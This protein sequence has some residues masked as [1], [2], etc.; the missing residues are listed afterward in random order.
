MDS[1]G[2]GK[3]NVESVWYITPAYKG[4]KRHSCL[5]CSKYCHFLPCVIGADEC[6]QMASWPFFAAGRL[7][8]RRRGSVFFVVVAIVAALLVL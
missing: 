6:W 4:A 2:D 8:C 1:D 7:D 5:S 3:P